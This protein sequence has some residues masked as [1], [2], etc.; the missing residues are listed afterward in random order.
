MSGGTINFD[1][2]GT[3]LVGGATNSIIPV[4]QTDKAVCYY[5]PSIVDTPLVRSGM[6]LSSQRFSLHTVGKYLVCFAG[7]DD[8][9]VVS[10]I[11]WPLAVLSERLSY[12]L[13]SLSDDDVKNRMCF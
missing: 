13:P 7:R 8:E 9:L 6:C 12:G 2:K 5:D 11:L 4:T 10:A 1:R 3:R